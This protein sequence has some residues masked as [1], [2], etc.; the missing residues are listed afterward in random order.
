MSPDRAAV[1]EKSTWTI[2]A[3]IPADLEYFGAAVIDTLP[4]GVSFI[5]TTGV[6]CT[7][8]NAPTDCAGTF[9]PE[10]I[11]AEL[12]PSGQKV[13][14][15][16]GNVTSS[17]DVRTV[18]ITYTAKVTDIP[19]NVDRDPADPLTNSATLNSNPESKENPTSA[20]DDF[21]IVG[22]PATADLVVVEPS[23][24]ITKTVST[25]TPTPGAAYTVHDHGDERDRRALEHGLQRDDH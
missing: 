4:V 6:A 14:W 10:P 16:L 11:G 13:G 25:T 2:T 7:Q 24:S 23:L 20:G 3:T 15:L 22:P 5:E 1:G 19:A 12:A 18:T 8:A 17:P 9:D 21:E